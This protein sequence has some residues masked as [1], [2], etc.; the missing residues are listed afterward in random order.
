MDDHQRN[1]YRHEI[2]WLENKIEGLA[3]QLHKK[4][5]KQ[6]EIDTLRRQIKE[7]EYQ[8]ALGI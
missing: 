3:K 7:K 2:K 8:I 4:P 6:K 5:S 1:Q